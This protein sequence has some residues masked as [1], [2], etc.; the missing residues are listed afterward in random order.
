MHHV[1][2]LDPR[3]DR[4][5]GGLQIAHVGEDDLRALP[6]ELE[7]DRLDV[8]LANR[9]KQRLAPKTETG[10]HVRPRQREGQ[11][12]GR[13]AKRRRLLFLSD[14]DGSWES[15]LGEFV[16]RAQDDG[17]PVVVDA[18]DLQLARLQP[19]LHEARSRAQTLAG[20]GVV[21]AH[22]LAA[23]HRVDPAIGDNGI[24]E[25]GFA[26]T[27]TRETSPVR[28]DNTPP[29]IRKL[30]SGGYRLYS[31]KK[32]PKTGRRRN[33]GTF[34]SLA[35]AKKHF[36]PERLTIVAVGAGEAL[37]KLLSGFGDVKEIALTQ[38]N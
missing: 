7:R 12:A 24:A 2:R 14:Y 22:R 21:G 1:E 9:A 4:R 38:K 17:Q 33:L 35:A 13:G 3:R 31:R 34:K 15:Y 19:A 16:D 5:G 6:P 25:Q 11:R 29:V 30:P 23:V 20:G 26:K 32:D 8:S 27:S 18:L 36:N 10:H 28:I 37:P